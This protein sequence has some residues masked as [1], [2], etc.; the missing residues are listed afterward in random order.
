MIRLILIGSN[1][2]CLPVE[3]IVR[4]LHTTKEMRMQACDSMF[5]TP[6]VEAIRKLIKQSSITQHLSALGYDMHRRDGRDGS[7]EIH[8][9]CIQVSHL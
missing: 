4:Y 5:Q 8:N 2:D 6:S 1:D 3:S 9:I 7:Y